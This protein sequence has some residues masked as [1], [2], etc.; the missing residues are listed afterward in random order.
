[1]FAKDAAIS[2][3]TARNRCHLSKIA[4]FFDKLSGVVHP[5]NTAIL[6][7]DELEKL[8]DT[9]DEEEL[10]ETYEAFITRAN[11]FRLLHEMEDYLLLKEKFKQSDVPARKRIKKKDRDN[12]IA[13]PFCMKTV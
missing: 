5:G 4:D 12:L 1:M 13:S 11:L 3:Q 7:L 8:R 9:F 2:H 6:Y 10:P